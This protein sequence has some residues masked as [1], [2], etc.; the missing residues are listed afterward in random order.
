MNVYISGETYGS[1]GG[2]NATPGYAD[3]WLA[4]YSATGAL[5]WKRQLGT[6]GTEFSEGVATDAN[7]N[8]YISGWTNGLLDG[9]VADEGGDAF[10]AKYYTRR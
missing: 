8:V 9:T 4:K 1:L 2:V 7:G 5:R 6:S 3:A 10:L